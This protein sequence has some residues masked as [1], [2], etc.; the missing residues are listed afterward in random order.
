MSYT[1][2][3]RCEPKWGRRGE[4]HPF[5]FGSRQGARHFLRPFYVP[6]HRDVRMRGHHLPGMDGKRPAD[7]QNRQPDGRAQGAGHARQNRLERPR[8]VR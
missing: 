2:S 8:T 4:A 1:E 6:E 3:K 5:H 7:D